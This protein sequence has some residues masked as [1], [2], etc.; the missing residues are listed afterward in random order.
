LRDIV[1]RRRRRAAGQA[2]IEF[3]LLLPVLLLI[4]VAIGDFG[5]V[6]V[7]AVA[8]EGGVRAAADY[9]AFEKS[10]WCVIDPGTS[11]CTSVNVAGTEAEMQ[12]RACTAVKALPDYV[13]AADGSTCSNPAFSYVLENAP[14]A[15]PY[16]SGC[17]LSTPGCVKVVHVTLAYDFHAAL[18]FPPLP[19]QVHIVRE[20]WFPIS[21]LPMG[22][23]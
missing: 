7:S 20:S 13:G 19:T 3:A 8:V 10:N 18:N 21:E 6:F 12:R 9:G 2:V 17:D 22:G 23:S 1:A 4:A 16:A 5:R 14:N 11:L 15:A